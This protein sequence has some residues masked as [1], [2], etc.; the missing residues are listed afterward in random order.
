MAPRSE[1]L[2]YPAG[3]ALASAAVTRG[4][5]RDCVIVALATVAAAAFAYFGGAVVLLAI[6]AITVLA[7]V[8]AAVLGVVAVRSELRRIASS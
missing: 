8:I 4:W 3:T 5:I 1:A 7:P 6:L 2:Q